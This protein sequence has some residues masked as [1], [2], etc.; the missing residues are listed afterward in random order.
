[1]QFLVKFLAIVIILSTVNSSLAGE[2]FQPVKSMELF[3]NTLQE[4]VTLQIQ[5]PSDYENTSNNYSVLYVLDGNFFMTQAVAAVDFLSTQ[6]YMNSLIPEQ[7]IVGIT[8]ADRDRDFTP[9]HDAEY[10]GMPFPTSGGGE[11]FFKFMTTELFSHMGE[12]YRVAEER[13][14]CGWSLGGLFTT[15]VYLEH[16]NTFNKYLA[17]SPSLWWDDGFVCDR[18]VEATVNNNLSQRNLTVTLGQL[19]KGAMEDSVEGRFLP[20]MVG[21]NQNFHFI[22][23]EGEGHNTSPYTALHK[24]LNSLY[25]LGPIPA[26][27]FTGN[28]SQKRDYILRTA[29]DNNFPTDSIG[30]ACGFLIKKAVNQGRLEAGLQIAD[31]FAIHLSQSSDAMLSLGE[32]YV[33]VERQEEAVETFNKAIERELSLEDP[34]SEKVKYFQEYLAWVINR[35]K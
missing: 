8:T 14:L 33:R 25:F 15:W 13:T 26:G 19:E 32:M 27:V 18:V 5:L 1:M 34:D 11:K 12:N 20:A 24:G 28:D 6:K 10:D 3:S 7:I 31:L 29:K 21:Q 22:E 35:A 2:V 9:T 23:I 16:S 4:D 30:Q 17:I